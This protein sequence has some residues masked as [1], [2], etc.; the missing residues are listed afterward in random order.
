MK[1]YKVVIV[2]DRGSSVPWS[3]LC[4]VEHYDQGISVV[5]GVG[6]GAGRDPAE[7]GEDAIIAAELAIVGKGPSPSQQTL[8]E[9]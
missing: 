2:E 1:I 4:E 6:R 5:H 7:A 9:V 3:G 8:G